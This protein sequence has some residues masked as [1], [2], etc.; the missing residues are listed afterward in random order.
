MKVKE[1]RKTWQQMA[2]T[3]LLKEKQRKIYK[4]QFRAVK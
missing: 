4:F 2:E 1:A 3:A